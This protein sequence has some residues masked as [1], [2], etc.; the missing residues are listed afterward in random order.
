M[1]VDHFEEILRE[2]VKHADILI[3]NFTPGT[4]ERWNLGWE[5]LRKVNPRRVSKRSDCSLICWANSSYS[6]GLLPR[7][8]CCR[9]ETLSGVQ[10]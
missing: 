3:E 2:L 7:T 4:L 8:A 1:F 6:A 5:D 9:R 10:A